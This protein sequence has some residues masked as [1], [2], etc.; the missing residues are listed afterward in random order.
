MPSKT[1]FGFD[2]EEE[3][4]SGGGLFGFPT[5][6]EDDGSNKSGFFGFPSTD[7]SVEK[8]EAPSGFSQPLSSMQSEDTDD[9][10]EPSGDDPKPT[11]NYAQQILDLLDAPRNLLQKKF[12]QS[13]FGKDA[14][15]DDGSYNAR[16]LRANVAGNGIG[17]GYMAE[18]GGDFRSDLSNLI[19]STFSGNAENVKQAGSELV[20]RLGD[21]IFDVAY[22]TASDPTMY[23]GGALSKGIKSATSKIPTELGKKAV[24]ASAYGGMLGAAN[25][26]AKEDNSELPYI[27]PVEGALVAP[28][29]PFAV[30]GAEKIKQYGDKFISWRLAGKTV[31][32][33][34]GDL[35]L[36][37]YPDKLPIVDEINKQSAYRAH[38][39][40]QGRLKS[41]QGLSDTDAV[42]V[43]QWMTQAKVAQNAL[44][45]ESYF[46]QGVGLFG[47]KEVTK[48]SKK[49]Y[50]TMDNALGEEREKFLKSYSAE[51]VDDLSPE[52]RREYMGIKPDPDEVKTKTIDALLDQQDSSGKL[53][54][55]IWNN[56]RYNAQERFMNGEFNEM[57]KALSDTQMPAVV[58]WANLN[59]EIKSAYNKAKKFDDIFSPDIGFFYATRKNPPT[60]GGKNLPEVPIS[61]T[62]DALESLKGQK[63]VKFVTP[64]KDYNAS[65]VVERKNT[66]RGIS[67]K[68]LKDKGLVPVSPGS[69][70]YV[71]PIK[72]QSVQNSPMVGFMFHNADVY[73]RKAFE[74]S[75]EIFQ[76]KS[77]TGFKR[78]LKAGESEAVERM[79]AEGIPPREAYD[80]A[81]GVYADGAA[82]AFLTNAE[83]EAVAIVKGAQESLNGPTMQ[84]YDALTG[85]FKKKVL[86]LSTSWAKMNYWDNTMK[87]LV[88]RGWGDAF[89]TARMGGISGDLAGKI[90]DVLRGNPST[91]LNDRANELLKY[92]VIGGDFY[93]EI[94]GLSD[95]EK[96][97]RYAPDSSAVTGKK[98]AAEKISDLGDSV[99]KIPGLKQFSDLSRKA[100]QRFEWNARAVTYDSIVSY[101]ENQALKDGKKITP[102][103]ADTIRR[104][105]SSAVKD[106]FFD[107]GK[108]TA[109]ERELGKRFLPFY[110]FTSK[111]AKYIADRLTD[112]KYTAG[113]NRLVN[114][115]NQ[116]GSS[117]SKDDEF[118]QTMQVQN[119]ALRAGNP[120]KLGGE[121]D[122]Y[123]T[124]AATPKLS[125]FEGLNNITDPATLLKGVNPFIKGL[126]EL[127]TK[128]D[129]YTGQPFD[130]E[131]NPYGGKNFVGQKGYA[132]LLAGELLGPEWTT[133]PRYSLDQVLSGEVPASRLGKDAINAVT[134]IQGVRP[135]EKTGSPETDSMATMLSQKGRE[136][137]PFLPAMKGVGTLY[138]VINTP[139]FDTIVQGTYQQ[140]KSGDGKNKSADL[141]LQMLTPLM[142]I[143]KDEQLLNDQLKKIDRKPRDEIKKYNKDKR[144][145][146][147][148][149]D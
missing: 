116:S 52:L 92:D 19:D 48:A 110:S 64:D 104:D 68:E 55:Y 142:I 60:Q 84:V 17:S 69:R 141:P 71:D 98:S 89:K 40:K 34:M 131:K 111:N 30:A 35:D 145:R 113:F 115:A 57:V 67:E 47:E 130:P 7:D 4:L 16:S 81:Y 143:K 119:D 38:M 50:K 103:L 18:R 9:T 97:L 144:I 83:R 2:D 121:G 12:Q 25:K 31:S 114:I 21:S 125:F 77:Q 88:E 72:L 62:D 76:S 42:A 120:R 43:N 90:D 26:A 54:G 32:T 128:R 122:D 66:Q 146:E 99:L 10:V 28:L 134:G 126:V 91:I 24:A 70:V 51:S 96:R 82:R 109:I 27:G 73:D 137:V 107:Y 106:I 63:R 3:S 13:Q 118:G 39:I 85:A 1:P 149:E 53:R 147:K 100:G 93:S 138:N 22:D 37:K 29:L 20:K 95:T 45:I 124:Y 44:T 148:S 74:T 140:M 8:E 112:P 11:L 65:V 129:S 127:G 79:I 6:E 59:E 94:A 5:N 139:L 86:F 108:V 117:A 49:M 75:K 87:V 78:G 23:V 123:V 80:R 14:V 36:S 41:L 58:E 56:S 33:P 135:N 132:G 61:F 133:K 46:G 101:L 105:A 102:E 136:L 15:T